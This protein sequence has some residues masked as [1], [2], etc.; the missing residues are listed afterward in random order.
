M[1][2]AHKIVQ[3]R[4]MLG[5][6]QEELSEKANINLRTLQRIEKGASDPRGHTLR[7]I[8][9]GLEV[10]VEE[11]MDY[12]KQDDPV[13]LQI[14]SLSALCYWVLPL[15]NILVP[16]ILWLFKRDKIQGADKL[17]KEILGFQLIWTVFA[18]GAFILF[19]TLK[20]MHLAGAQYFLWA[21]FVLYFLNTIVIVQSV[22]RLRKGKVPAYPWR[23]RF[24]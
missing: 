12:S 6:S 9:E 8:A 20:I 1:S 4:K 22:F 21:G 10:P 15:L 18:Y 5:M 7:A 13:F 23:L 3:N 2:L 19:A 11:L 17:G 16:L 24:V 14:M